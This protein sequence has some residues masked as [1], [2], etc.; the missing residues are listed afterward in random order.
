MKQL[1]RQQITYG[2]YIA[3]VCAILMGAGSYQY[4][5]YVDRKNKQQW[6]EVVSTL[7]DAYKANPPQTTTGK[8]LAS[9]FS[10]MRI[11]FRCPK[12]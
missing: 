4:S 2:G 1:T 5:N 7:D 9:E 12:E 11:D 3:L 6:C 10:R 8:R